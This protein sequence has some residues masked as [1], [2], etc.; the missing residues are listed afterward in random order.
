MLTVART[1]KDKD[2]LSNMMAYGED[3]A[4]P[5]SASLQ[6]AREKM[7]RAQLADLDDVDDDRFDECKCVH[8]LCID[9]Y[10]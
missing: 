4:P 1:Q 10:C 5:T 8:T 9:S 7:W 6:A 2:R 3:V